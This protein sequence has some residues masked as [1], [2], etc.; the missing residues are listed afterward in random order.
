MTA[1]SM[2]CITPSR[3]A[4]AHRLTTK[5]PTLAIPA[6]LHHQVRTF[7]K[8]Q[9]PEGSRTG[10]WLN[11]SAPG[12]LPSEHKGEGGK[13]PDERTLKLGKTIRIL[14]ERLPT[15][16]ASPLPQEILSPH[17]TLHLFPS[18]H[19]HLPNV[20]GRIAYTAAL[21][22]APVAWGRVPVVGNVRLEILSERMA[23]NGGSST[24]GVAHEKL[25]V[26][27]KT[28]GKTKGKG[29][30]ALYRGISGS[31][32]VDKITEFLG[33]DAKDDEE[34]VGLFIFE[35]DEEGRII[36]HTIEH[37]EEGGNWDKMTRVISVTDWLLGKAWGAKHPAG[38]ALGF[39]KNEDLYRRRPHSRN[40]R[41]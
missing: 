19:P 17:I 31:E 39:C 29:V 27:W 26:K 15:L 30:G 24:P 22:T 28:C 18:T 13:P 36:T 16:L 9:Q 35:F 20:S 40:R 23:R 6:A 21:W 5:K 1:G 34:F 41:Y 4:R 33:G 12:S 32:Q 38:L 25:V 11:S 7:A 14:H 3:L 10:E 37:A 2:R 8:V